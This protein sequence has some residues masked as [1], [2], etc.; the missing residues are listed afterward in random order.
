MLNRVMLCSLGIV[1]G[2]GLLLAHGDATHLM[3][4]VSSIDTAKNIFVIKQ[5]DGKTVSVMTDKFTKYLKS[6][7]KPTPSSELKVGVRVVVDAKMDKTAKM[8][9]AEEVRVGVA[10]PAATA[11]KTASATKAAP[12]K[13]TPSKP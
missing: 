9:V 11:A 4:T 3:G 10:A 6:D 7:S 12:Q 1:L 13:A 8:F 5:A 2:A